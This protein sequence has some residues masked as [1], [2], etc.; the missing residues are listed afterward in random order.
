MEKGTVLAMI[1]WPAFVIY[2]YEMLDE[3]YKPFQAYVSLD[4]FV[5]QQMEPC[6]ETAWTIRENR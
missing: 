6:W 1:Y 4:W 2:W 3:K 5:L